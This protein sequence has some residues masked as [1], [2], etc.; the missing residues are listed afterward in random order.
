M[1]L[2]L[3]R[4]R[5]LNAVVETGSMSAAAQRLRISQP[6][7]TQSIRDL[8]REAGLRLFEKRGRE[9]VPTALCAELHRLT[10]QAEHWER[11]A[12]RL[13][14]QHAAL[15][16]GELHVGLGNSMPGLALIR[17]F[18]R[19]CPGVRIHVELGSWSQIIEA[20][21]ERRVEVGVLPNVPDDGRFA[22]TTCLVQDVVAIV[23][24]DTALAAQAQVTCA[25]LIRHPLIF[26]TG[27]SSTQRVVDAGFRRAGLAP[28]PS[29]VLDT[30]DGV[31]EA[32]ANGLGVGFMWQFGSSRQDS[33]RR[34]RVIDFAQGHPEHIFHLAGE[35]GPL[36]AIFAAIKI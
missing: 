11:R 30:R 3:A 2:T 17:A 20:V 5:A 32:A 1:A 19:I 8:E 36:V 27:R 24:E 12:A 4:I 22:R 9:L 35:T 33:I 7:V 28:V 13:L 16:L 14:Q 25:E 10:A 31:Y 26:R 34:L 21:V 29:L 18:R 23:A 15:E 6:A